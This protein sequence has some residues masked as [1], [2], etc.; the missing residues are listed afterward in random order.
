MPSSVKCRLSFHLFHGSSSFSGAVKGNGQWEP[1]V[2]WQ[3][4]QYSQ[5]PMGGRCTKYI[6]ICWWWLADPSWVVQL[7]YITWHT[8]PLGESIFTPMQDVEFSWW[9]ESVHRG[10]MCCG[11]SATVGDNN[12]KQKHAGYQ[13]RKCPLRTI[14]VSILLCS[15][16]I[17]SDWIGLDNFEK[18]YKW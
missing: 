8:W 15:G 11:Q 17:G 3:Y 12:K 9:A 6:V 10:H 13:Q 1:V 7:F 18:F 16:A 14:S 5:R 4:S 2:Q